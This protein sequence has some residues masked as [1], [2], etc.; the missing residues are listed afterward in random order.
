[1]RLAVT[2]PRPATRRKAAAIVEFAVV[3]PV[4]FLLVFGMLEFSRLMMVEQI[5]GNASRE[6]ARKAALPGTTQSDVTTAVNSYLSGSGITGATV[7]VTPDPASAASG[8][9]VT[10]NVQ[11]PFA[12]VSWLPQ[13]VFLGTAKVN[14]SVV[15]RKESNNS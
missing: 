2:P 10:V 9:A 5:L 3:A 8:A 7:S 4:L 12:K 11:V 14:A 1:M 15:M 6:G 13:P